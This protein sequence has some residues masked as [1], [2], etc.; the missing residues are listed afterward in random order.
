MNIGLLA[1]RRIRLVLKKK[2][3]AQVKDFLSLRLSKNIILPQIAY[4][5]G[6]PMRVSKLGRRK[7]KD[8]RSEIAL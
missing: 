6:Q 7:L 5:P 8:K 1:D 2:I 3:N 4:N